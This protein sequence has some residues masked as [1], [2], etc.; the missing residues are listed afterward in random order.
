[1]PKYSISRSVLTQQDVEIQAGYQQRNQINCVNHV[2]NYCHEF[3]FVQF[4]YSLMPVLK[5][6]PK[7]SI[8]DNL[9]G[10]ISAGITVAVMHIPQGNIH[11]F[12]NIEWQ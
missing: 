11:H 4:L 12:H 7:Y 5:W 9:A 8:K 1:M 6:L 3:S 10:D 2:K